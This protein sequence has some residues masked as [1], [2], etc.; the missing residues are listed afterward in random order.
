MT[1]RAVPFAVWRWRRTYRTA[2][3]PGRRAR[4]STWRDRLLVVDRV[5]PTV[6]GA[7][8]F[9]VGTVLA[10]QTFTEI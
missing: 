9:G 6:T 7:V 2:D 3:R 10:A 4:T 8:I 5:L 1:S